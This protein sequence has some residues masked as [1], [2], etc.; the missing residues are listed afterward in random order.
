MIMHELDL[1]RAAKH[2]RTGDLS[3][4][5]YGEALIAQAQSFAAL[6]AFIELDLDRIRKVARDADRHK[7]RGHMLGP[8]HGIPLA[9]KDCID[10]AE[11]PTTGATPALRKNV[12]RRTAPLVRTLFE[13][14]AHLFGKTNLYELAFG[15]TSN[16]DCTGAVRNPHNPDRSAGGS[17]S[18]SAAAVAAG[19]VPAA[20][21]SDTAGSIRIPAAHCGIYG[22]RPTTGRYASDG[23]MPCFPTR[24]A[25]GLLA[26]SVED[27]CL[28]DSI[29][30]AER[31]LP[32]CNLEGLRLGLPGPYF[33]DALESDV[34]IAF[35]QELRRLESCGVRLVDAA[36]PNFAALIAEA[37][38]P[39]RAWEL[40]RSLAAYLDAS[41][42]D[43][44]LETGLSAI[45]GPYVR[46]EFAD[47]LKGQDTA[48]LA[49]RY[50]ETLSVVL[51]RHREAY[52]GYLADNDL[53]AIVF[54]TTPLAPTLLGEEGDVL[55]DGRMV[56][57]WHTMRNTVPASFYGAPAITIPYARTPAGLPLGLEF[58]GI[59]GQDR[60]L[61]AIAASWARTAQ[62][63]RMN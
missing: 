57:V 17:S 36:P 40:P 53:N 27:L 59:P 4:E 47:A 50:Q 42:C 22:F 30:T 25:P 55:I 11:L 9:V 18:G 5:E 46:E 32:A 58:D 61:L 21:G 52:R 2:L 51:P 49:E 33:L 41:A 19:M 16:N 45:A 12:D 6:N 38:E 63:S 62:N 1:T 34:A 10:I 15:I 35:E 44:D 28:L 37:S 23:F 7:A 56:S 20:I 54:P 13:A 29:L 24:D 8:L 14:G 60:K 3:A 31:D 43:I 48:D 26:R 39:I